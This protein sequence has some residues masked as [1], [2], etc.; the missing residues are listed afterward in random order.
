M[1]IGNNFVIR[2]HLN[3][4]NH[5]RISISHLKKILFFN[6]NNLAWSYFLFNV[7]YKFQFP[8]PSIKVSYNIV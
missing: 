8:T 2:M 6:I 4:E 3:K 7:K 5:F 1:K